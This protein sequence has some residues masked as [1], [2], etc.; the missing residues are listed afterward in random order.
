M[1]GS[2]SLKSVLPALVP[3]LSYKELEVQD[4]T[5][6]MEVY[7]S[8][9]DLGDSAAATAQREALWEYCKM[10]TLAMVRVLDTLRSLQS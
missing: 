7:L 1:G 9:E 2:V 6:A 8:L 3:E 4:G 10:D 5:Q